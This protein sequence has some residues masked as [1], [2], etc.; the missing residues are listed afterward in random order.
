MVK[1]MSGDMHGRKLLLAIVSLCV[2]D[3]TAGYQFIAELGEYSIT[4]A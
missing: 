3:A 1:A 4:Q 2:I